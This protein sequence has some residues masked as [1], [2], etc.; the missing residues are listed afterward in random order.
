MFDLLIPVSDC[1]VLVFQDFRV[2]FF[3]S[4]AEI[5]TQTAKPKNKS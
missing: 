2:C 5:D 4:Y 3:F 1:M